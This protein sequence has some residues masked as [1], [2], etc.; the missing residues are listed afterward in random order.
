MRKGT[1][2][3]FNAAKGYGFITEGEIFIETDSGLSI[4]RK[5]RQGM[6]DYKSVCLSRQ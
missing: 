3:W 2:K 6:T 5:P 1:V 4:D